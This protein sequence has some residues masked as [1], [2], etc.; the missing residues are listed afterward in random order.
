MLKSKSWKINL[1]KLFLIM[2]LGTL[3]LSAIGCLSLGLG[4]GVLTNKDKSWIILKGS[5]FTAIQAPEY[6]IPTKFLA[7][8]DLLVLYKGKYLEQEKAWSSKA[9]KLADESKVRGLFLGIFGS[10]I[11]AAAAMLVKNMLSKKEKS[12]V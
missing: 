11:S 1:H 4:S 5:E 6:K 12:N 2:I 7:E 3:T 8:D 9:W 10:I